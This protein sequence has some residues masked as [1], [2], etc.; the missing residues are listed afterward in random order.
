MEFLAQ[1]TGFITRWTSKIH[2]FITKWSNPE[3]L[4]KEEY[5]QEII[6]FQSVELGR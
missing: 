6:S 4:N 1:P 2:M 3:R 5:L